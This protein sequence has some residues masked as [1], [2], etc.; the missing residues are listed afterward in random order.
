MSAPGDR[1]VSAVLARLHDEAAGDGARWAERRQ[2]QAREFQFPAD[3]GK[4]PEHEE[5]APGDEQPDRR[6]LG[7]LPEKQHRSDQER[8]AGDKIDGRV[9]NLVTPIDG[10]VRVAGIKPGRIERSRCIGHSVGFPGWLGSA[11]EMPRQAF[12]SDSGRS[13]MPTG[14]G[15]FPPALA[16]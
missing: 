9:G 14:N 2:R 8:R 1:S 11:S 13:P 16:P 4:R 6:R 15:R 3:A 7:R 10:P 12:G 5:H